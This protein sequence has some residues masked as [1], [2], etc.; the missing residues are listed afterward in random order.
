[1][2]DLSSGHGLGIEKF[3][4]LPSNGDDMETQEI[5]L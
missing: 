2:G 5:H 3:L 4:E 1:M